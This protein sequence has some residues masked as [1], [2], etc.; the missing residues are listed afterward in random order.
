MGLPLQLSFIQRTRRHPPAQAAWRDHA[1]DLI[2]SASDESIATIDNAGGAVVW[3]DIIPTTELKRKLGWSIDTDALVVEFR[4]KLGDS[5]A[6]RCDDLNGA[7]MVCQPNS[8]AATYRLPCELPDC[9]RLSADT[10]T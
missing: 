4:E 8:T 2:V 5:S 9:P 3:I 10:A 6:L 1:R 7:W